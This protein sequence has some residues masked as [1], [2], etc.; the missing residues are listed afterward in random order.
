MA[1]HRTV[2]KAAVNGAADISIHGIRFESFSSAAGDL[3]I[4]VDIENSAVIDAAANQITRMCYTA[5]PDLCRAGQGGSSLIADT[6]AHSIS[7]QLSRYRR[8][9][10]DAA[11]GHGERAVFSHVHAAAPRLHSFYRGSTAHDIAAGHGECAAVIYIHTAAGDYVP[12]NA[13]RAAVDNAAVYGL[14]AAGSPLPKAIVFRIEVICRCKVA[15]FQRQMTAVFNLDNA[16]AAG[17]FKHIAVNIQC[18]SAVNCQGGSDRNVTFQC[19]KAHIAVCQRVNQFLFRFNLFGC[20]TLG[21][22]TCWHKADRH[23]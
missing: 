4:A 21:E 18:D 3:H 2:K 6:A 20:L 22:H 10:G 9:A 5:F 23:T 15:V 8:A 16:A 13:A 1:P 12:V 17:N 19:D 7:A 11:A 14:C